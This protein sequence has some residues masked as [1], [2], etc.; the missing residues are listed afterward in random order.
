M[1]KRQHLVRIDVD[2]ASDGGASVPDLSGCVAAGRTIDTALRGIDE[3]IQ[4][5]LS[6]L[7]EDAPPIPAP[8]RRAIRVARRPVAALGP[9]SH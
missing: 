7:R 6:G 9:H 4:I 5:D 1:R 3:A 8:G 2:P